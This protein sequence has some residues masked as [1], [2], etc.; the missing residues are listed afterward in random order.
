MTAT[1]AI[2]PHHPPQASD[3][4]PETSALI[5]A[6]VV[7]AV[8]RTTFYRPAVPIGFRSVP[9]APLRVPHLTVPKKRT[10]VIAFGDL[11]FVGFCVGLLLTGW[12]SLLIGLNMAEAAQR[13]TRACIT[14]TYDSAVSRPALNR[15]LCDR[16]S[17]QG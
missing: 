3:P 10:R 8:R 13:M 7:R 4:A 9:E 12:V 5:E 17:Q 6:A 14:Q 11:V 16:L 15:T 2:D 1:N